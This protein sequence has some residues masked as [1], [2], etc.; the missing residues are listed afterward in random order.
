MWEIAAIIEVLERKGLCTKHDLYDIITEFCRMY[1]RVP[2]SLK[3]PSLSL[4][5]S[6]KPKTRSLATFSRDSTSTA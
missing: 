5:S 6:P 3:P 1:P 2:A 4:P